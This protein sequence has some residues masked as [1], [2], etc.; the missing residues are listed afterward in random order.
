[1]VDSCVESTRIPPLRLI[2]KYLTLL[3]LEVLAP[4]IMTDDILDGD[5][6]LPL[7]KYSPSDGTERKFSKLSKLSNNLRGRIHN[8]N[9]VSD[10]EFMMVQL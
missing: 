10:P 2:G 3:I 7:S 1:M 4:T 6:G 5:S 9:R 8:L